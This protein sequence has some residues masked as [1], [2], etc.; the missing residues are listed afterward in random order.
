MKRPTLRVLFYPKHLVLFY[1]FFRALADI[2]RQQGPVPISQY[3]HEN[4][5]AIETSPKENTPV[6]TSKNH[7]TPVHNKTNHGRSPVFVRVLLDFTFKN[8]WMK[9]QRCGFVRACFFLVRN[10]KLSAC[11]SP[12]RSYQKSH[13]N[14]FFI[15]AER[16]SRAR[17]SWCA[18]LPSCFFTLTFT[19]RSTTNKNRPYVVSDLFEFL[20]SGEDILKNVGETYLQH[21]KMMNCS[22]I[23]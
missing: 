19:S 21:E 13:L 5:A 6:R 18:L 3:E 22:F 20:S 8:Q 4:I 14:K 23:L 1:V 10:E 2:L 9:R 11:C 12:L 16:R 17:S 15:H 7:Y